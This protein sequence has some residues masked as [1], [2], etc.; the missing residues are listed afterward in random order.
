MPGQPPLPHGSGSSPARSSEPC[1][2][3]TAEA[4]VLF[5]QVASQG[6][7]VRKLKAEK[8]SKVGVLF[9][10]C[11]CFSRYPLFSCPME[12]G[13]LLMFQLPALLSCLLE[14]PSVV[15]S[16]PT[17]SDCSLLGLRLSLTSYLTALY[18]N[19]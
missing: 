8:A 19:C 18:F 3:E 5:D 2:P 15:L 12:S 4:K 17:R 13:K 10:V 14:K 7:V 16:P 1:G 6:E 11:F 9:C